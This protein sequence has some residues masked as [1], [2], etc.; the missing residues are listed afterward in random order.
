MFRIPFLFFFSGI[1][2]CTTENEE[3]PEKQQDSAEIDILDIDN[4]GDG[5]SE[6]E[7]DCDDGNPDIS[8]LANEVCDGIDNDC[9]E[10]IDTEDDNF[11]TSSAML[12]YQDQDQDG[13]G[14]ENTATWI[15]EPQDGYVDIVGDCDDN[16]SDVH[17]EAL[18]QCDD[19]DN[20]CD[21]DIDDAD[22]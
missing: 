13:F 4:D 1:L 12:Y 7:G 6:N 21:G 9:D 20:D 15:C 10:L 14:D 17:P 2:G 8:P 3:E 16:N 22:S 5:V 19:I 18:E 11:D